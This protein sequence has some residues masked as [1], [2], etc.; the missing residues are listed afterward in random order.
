MRKNAPLPERR[1]KKKI[2]KRTSA[3][4]HG[5]RRKKRR[6]DF[7]TAV[8][9]N[10]YLLYSFTVRFTHVQICVRRASHSASVFPSDAR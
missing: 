3:S 8:F 6:F 2:K 4:P 1:S 5:K 7:K 10:I 9:V